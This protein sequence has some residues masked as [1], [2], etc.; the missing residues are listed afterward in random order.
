MYYNMHG[1]T[2]LRLAV[3]MLAGV[4][5]PFN[6]T[7]PATLDLEFGRTSIIVVNVSWIQQDGADYDIFISPPIPYSNTSRTS[8]IIPNVPFNVQ[9]NVTVVAHRCHGGY[10]SSAMLNHSESNTAAVIIL[11]TNL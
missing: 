7:L 4:P 8:I 2:I 9:Y 3:S 1:C 6:L 5:T 10:T 11:I